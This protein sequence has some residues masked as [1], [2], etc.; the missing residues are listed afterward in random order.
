M[1]EHKVLLEDV[2]INIDVGDVWANFKP[3]QVRSCTNTRVFRLV[4]N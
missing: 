3:I 1:D 2:D 4:Y